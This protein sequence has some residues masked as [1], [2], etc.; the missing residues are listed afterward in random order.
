MTAVSPEKITGLILAG[1]QARRMGP[2]VDKAWVTLA[3]RPL[4]VW[5]LERLT[6]QVGRVI[7]S[8][9]GDPG[10]FASLGLP[11]LPDRRHTPHGPLAGLESAFLGTDAAWIL[12]VAVDL[13]FLPHDLVETMR[14]RAVCS[15]PETVLSAHAGACRPV[16][17][18]SGKRCH[19][20][21]CL[22]PRSVLTTLGAALD[23]GRFSLRAWFQRY[24]HHTATFSVDDQGVDPFFNIN[25][26]EDVQ[27]AEKML[28]RKQNKQHPF[29]TS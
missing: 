11:V 20:V 24:P 9:N 28:E 22:W 23:Q 15:A 12:S 26:S 13:P 6:P 18:M 7:L 8:A 27:M 2:G 10:R 29:T 17:A 14:G 25:R 16:L 21:V 5:V 3:G 19:Y 4:V 1:G